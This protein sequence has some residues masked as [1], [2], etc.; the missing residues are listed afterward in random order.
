MKECKFTFETVDEAVEKIRKFLEGVCGRKEARK[1]RKIWV[2]SAG[3]GLA[4]KAREY[5]DRN[6][7]NIKKISEVASFLGCSSRTLRRRFKEEYGLSPREYLLK[8]R[9]EYALCLREEG[10]LWK[11]IA[12]MAGYSS[13]SS[14]FRVLS[15]IRKKF[16]KNGKEKG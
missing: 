8:L 16:P 15:E 13:P 14:L 7:R 1:Q 6:F 3:S 11:Q 9:V 4:Q 12:E 5:M 2:W 10:Y